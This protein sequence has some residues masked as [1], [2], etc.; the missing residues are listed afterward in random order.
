L[1]ILAIDTALGATAVAILDTESRAVLAEASRVMDR[2]QGE[3][4]MPMV[5]DVLGA[6]GLG[7]AAIDRFAVTIGPG[8]FTGL[9]IGIAAARGFALVHDRPVVGVS[10]LS[11]FSA[12]VLFGSE[13][14]TV[15]AAIDARH[16]MIFFQALNRDGRAIAGPMLCPIEEAARKIGDGPV[17]FVG[18][19]ADRLASAR[20]DAMFD[21][22]AGN[23]SVLPAPEIAW[24]AR[25]G[26]VADPATA[27]A[28]PLYM[29]EVSVTLSDRARLERA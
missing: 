3:A 29:R 2:G 4:L 25:L 16:G 27:P 8:S 19:A 14:R 7:F 24:V 17:G 28:R 1:R 21:P 15:A 18:N 10:T 12:P 23:V 6:A 5:S 20:R 26:A 22:R 9:R 11:A 13:K